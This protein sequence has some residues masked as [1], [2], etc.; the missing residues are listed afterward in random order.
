MMNV[1]LTS[2]AERT[3]EIG[4]RRAVG[5]RKKDILY[6]FLIESC[7]LSALGGIFG[8]ILGVTLAQII[9]KL[10]SKVFVYPAYVKPFFSLI[11]ICSAML[12][13][14]VFGLYPSVKASRLSAADALRTE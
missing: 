10:F 3:R 8:L 9:P 7:V 12:L 2:V 4:I 1:M 14:V 5:A 6:Q 11:A 13:G